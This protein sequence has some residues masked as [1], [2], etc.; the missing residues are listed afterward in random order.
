MV[1]D[2]NDLVTAEQGSHSTK[3]FSVSHIIPLVSWVGLHKELG[4]FTARTA[5]PNEPKR[6]SIS[7]DIILSS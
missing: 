6:Y 3:A 4:G 1:D 2:T 7:Y 5:D